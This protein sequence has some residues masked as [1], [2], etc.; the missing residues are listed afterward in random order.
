MKP[1]RR[2]FLHFAAGAGALAAVSW[3]A[4]AQTYPSRPITMIM[5]IAA[6]S[7]SD[8]VGR[9]IVE[10]MRASLRQ[11]I[12]IE[13]VSGADGS[14]GTRQGERAR[15]DGY[16]I[17]FGFVGAMVMN[18]AFYSLPYDVLN[19][20]VAVSPLV[21]FSVVLFGRKTIPAQNLNELIAWLKAN[22][23]K[24]S[25]GI[26]TVGFRL[27]NVFFQNET[28]TQFTLVPYRGT[29]PVMQDLL[30]GQIDLWFGSTDQFPLVR[31]GSIKAYAVAS[32]IRMALA[33]DIPTFVE[34]GLPTISYPGWSGLFAPKGT[35]KDIINKL[36][37]A[38]VEA[39]ADTAVRSRLLDS[40]LQNTCGHQVSTPE[41][42]A[43]VRW[44]E[45]EASRAAFFSVSR[46]RP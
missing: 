22:P 19:D 5:P 1:S 32:D 13:N 12:I 31:E 46:E 4:E 36:N 10:R 16:T 7:I 24:A 14:I 44:N 18:A 23:N 21:K 17:I 30:A 27:L 34:M 9:V 8:V 42:G 45:G 35:P 11:P 29:P 43:V 20:F 33:P 26:T 41:R 3:D 39:L 37:A 40:R 25:A 6:G 28:R 15:P 2:T 38:V